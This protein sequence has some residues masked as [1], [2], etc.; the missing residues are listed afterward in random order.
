MTLSGWATPG[1]M[2][3]L[4]QHQPLIWLCW[5]WGAFL[6]RLEMGLGHPSGSR[7]IYNSL[8]ALIYT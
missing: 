1:D 3:F 5:G 4:E 6:Y 7:S 8:S 2:N